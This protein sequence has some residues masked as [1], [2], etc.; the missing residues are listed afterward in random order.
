M[1]ALPVAGLTLERADG[2]GAAKH[3]DGRIHLDLLLGGRYWAPAARDWVTDW[4]A[5]GAVPRVGAAA[6]GRWLLPFALV[7]AWRGAA[8]RAARSGPTLASGG[9]CTSPPSAPTSTGV[10]KCRATPDRSTFQA[11]SG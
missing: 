8:L 3:Q 2:A 4:V 5:N 10:S 7:R 11:Q 6:L 1:G 9:R